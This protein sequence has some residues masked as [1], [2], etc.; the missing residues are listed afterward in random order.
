MSISSARGYIRDLSGEEL[1]Q[2][3]RDVLVKKRALRDKSHDRKADDSHDDSF[4]EN[5]EVLLSD[6]VQLA[7]K[8]LVFSDSIQKTIFEL[9][10]KGGAT[11][12]Y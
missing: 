4:R 1:L 3:L 6:R 2:R 11:N 8:S 7:R 12:L 10:D 5:E 9:R